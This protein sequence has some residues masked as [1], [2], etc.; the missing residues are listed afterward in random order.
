MINYLGFML[1]V[2]VT[3]INLLLIYAAH[4]VIEEVQPEYV[5]RIKKFLKKAWGR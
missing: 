4:R 1:A 3:L 2:C 5:Q